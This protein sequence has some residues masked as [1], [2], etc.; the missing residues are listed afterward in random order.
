LFVRAVRL[1]EGLAKHCLGRQ[2]PDRPS[3][4]MA[5]ERARRPSLRRAAH[6]RLHAIGGPG[7]PPAR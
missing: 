3:R 7:C 2:R 5:D 4:P 1:L 6:P